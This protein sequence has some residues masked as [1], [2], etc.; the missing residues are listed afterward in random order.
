MQQD[1]LPP[2]FSSISNAVRYV[3]RKSSNEYSASCPQCGGEVH[4]NGSFPDR[5]VMFVV[6][7]YGTP[8]GFCRKCGYR[9][10][11]AKGRQPSKDEVEEWRK[12]QIEVEQARIESA[13]RTI[14]MLQNDRV[15]EVF[16]HKNNQ[17]SRDTFRGWGISDTWQKYCQLGLIEDYTVKSGDES[18]HSPAFSIPV[19][20]VG[21]V[22]QNI[23][24]RVANPRTDRDRYRN[25]Y[26]MGQSFLFV[27]LYDVP[28][29]GRCVLVEGYK[30]AVVME[31]TLDDIGLRVVGISGS[32][33]DPE[34]FKQLK[35]FET[36][37][38]WLDPD[39]HIPVLDKQG[40]PRETPVEYVTRMVGK[41]RVRVVNCPVKSDDGIVQHGIDPRKYLNMAV[42]A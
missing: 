2:E 36:V 32:T 17:W 12:R 20:H 30:K 10:T 1:M 27:P 34:L 16:F 33:P 39:A 28:L 7:R 26:S 35:D 18:Y 38:V 37:Y 19:W 42:K 4:K 31:Q 41:E 11:P 14:E 6:G 40:K 5:F 21:G 13:K 24:L 3:H 23:Q 22:V 29:N 15:W 8:L 25:F 9:W